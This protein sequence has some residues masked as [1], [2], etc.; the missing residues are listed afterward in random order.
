MKAV[1]CVLAVAVFAMSAFISSA[2]FNFRSD[3]TAR[4]LSKAESDNTRGSFV[5]N[6]P[7][8]LFKACGVMPNCLTNLCNSANSEGCSGNYTT[9]EPDANNV[10]CTTLNQLTDC[11]SSDDDFFESP[12]PCAHLRGACEWGMWDSSG[13]YS[14]RESS[15]GG[16]TDPVAPDNCST[17]PWQ[18]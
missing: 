7:R 5:H 17:V 3:N 16:V 18:Q 15:G 11:D 1:V 9:P 2:Y 8:Q 13:Q 14:C 12:A 6:Y 4:L 10:G